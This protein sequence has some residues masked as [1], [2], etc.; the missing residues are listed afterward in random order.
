MKKNIKNY[1]VGILLCVIYV[2]YRYYEIKMFVV[3]NIDRYNII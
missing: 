3:M 1:L 2:N